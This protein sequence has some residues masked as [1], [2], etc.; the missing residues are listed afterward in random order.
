M[1]KNS[2]DLQNKHNTSTDGIFKRTKGPIRYVYIALGIISFGLGA[3]GTVIPFIPTT[4][5]VL[6][7]V[8]CFSKSSKKLHTWLLSTKFYRN[9]LESLT[10]Q[11]AMTIKSKLTM[12][13][14]ITMFMGISFIVMIIVSAPFISRAVLSVIW[15]LH[16]L[17]FSFRIKTIG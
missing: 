6:L 17:Y 3:I 13:A 8:V 15:L 14:V 11:R 1:S 10:K 9:N 7:S 5:L 2:T 16:M 4:P 12:L